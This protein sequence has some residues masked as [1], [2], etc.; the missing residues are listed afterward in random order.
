MSIVH[1]R[2]QT[3]VSRIRLRFTAPSFLIGSEE[4]DDDALARPLDEVIHSRLPPISSFPFGTVLVA[5]R[6]GLLA[7]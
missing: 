6:V 5:A 3:R 1:S 4:E 7:L 2:A